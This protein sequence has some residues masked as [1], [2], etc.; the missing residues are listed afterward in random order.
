MGITEAKMIFWY[1]FTRHILTSILW[2]KKA[3]YDGGVFDQ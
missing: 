2:A 3:K 1:N